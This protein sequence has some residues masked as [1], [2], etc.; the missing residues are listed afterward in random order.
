MFEPNT[1]V[2]DCNT[3]VDAKKKNNECRS[4]N[5]GISFMPE[6]V[7]GGNK[8]CLICHGENKFKVFQCPRTLCDKETNF[9][10]ECQYDL[11]KWGRFPDGC[12]RLFQPV[13]LLEAFS[14]VRAVIDRKHALEMAK[15]GK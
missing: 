9:I 1:F 14:V 12:G 8:N 5:Y 15:Q 6:C 11:D 13:K 3:C 7:C 10:V 4:E 2:F